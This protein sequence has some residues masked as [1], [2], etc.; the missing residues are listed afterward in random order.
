MKRVLTAIPLILLLVIILEWLDPLFFSL[1]VAL[2]ATLA[3]NEYYTITI[4]AGFEPYRWFG[5][6]ASWGLLALFHFFP[7]NSP[8]LLFSLILAGIFILLLGLKRGDRLSS[9]LPG[10]ALTFFG[11]IYITLPLA[12]FILIRLR[13][14]GQGEANRWIFLGLLTCWVSD[15][16]AF[17]VGKLWGHHRL[18]PQVS[19]KKTWEGAVGGILGSGLAA[20]FGKL[21]LLPSLPWETILGVSLVLGMAGQLG[22]L[23]E[24]TLKR[25]A[26]VKDSSNLLP[27][28]GG[29]LDRIDAVLFVAP[30]LY[31]FLFWFVH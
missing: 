3:L 13:Y 18:A 10:S 26:G 24:S 25:G 21:V 11:I 30:V 5:H 4:T 6:G 1:V 9:T 15:T 2:V 17:C 16:A 8:L 31:G 19:P 27:G 22:D 20:G 23:S 14:S 28:H 12:L 29:M 7:S